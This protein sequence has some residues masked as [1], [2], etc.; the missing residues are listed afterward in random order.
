[1]YMRV[2]I[3]GATGLVGKAIV[4]Q[5]MAQ[6][7]EVHYLTTSKSKIEDSKSFKGFY[8]NPKQNEIDEA[9]FEGVNTII[10]LAGA[11]ISKRW[12]KSYRSN[13]LNSRLNSLRLLFSSLK[14]T[15][16]SVEQLICASA[17]GAYPDSLINY[18]EESFTEY[19]KSYL[20]EV[21]EK[22]EK[23]A[24]AFSNIGINVSKIR[25]GL[26]MDAKEGALPKIIK[27]TKWGL[28]TAFGNGKQWQSWIH[29]DDLASIFMYVAQ[30]QFNGVFNAV[31]PNPVTNEDFTK[32]VAKALKR[33]LILPNIPK[34]MMKLILG[35][36]H[37]L[38]FESQRVSSKK[39][40]DKGFKFE[41]INLKQALKEL[42]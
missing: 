11:S 40:E 39:I 35:E 20:G 42:I 27:P 32:T 18:Y 36:M 31:A 4:K 41:Y 30:H 6:K 21:V 17:I 33:P 3:T 8:W 10:N 29:V 22:W 34:F 1:M 2:L 23:E 9:C 12:T 7:I 16:N 24:D 14:K 38:L 5:C 19:S 15:N 28:G 37:I 26:V 25:I 13:I